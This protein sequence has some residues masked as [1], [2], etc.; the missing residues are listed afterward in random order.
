MA[1]ASYS[2]SRLCARRIY[3]F[4]SKYTKCGQILSLDGH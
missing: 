3:E 4:F 1:E 2:E